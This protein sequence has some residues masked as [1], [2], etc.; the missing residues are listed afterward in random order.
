VLVDVT[1]SVTVVETTTDDVTVMS[2]VTV[3]VGPGTG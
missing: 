2:F 3:V 1:L